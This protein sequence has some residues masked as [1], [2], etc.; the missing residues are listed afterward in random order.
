MVEFFSLNMDLMLGKIQKLFRILYDEL[1]ARQASQTPMSNAT[2]TLPASHVPH[3]RKEEPHP[4]D[5]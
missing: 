1:N 5:G 4:P 3:L 2:L